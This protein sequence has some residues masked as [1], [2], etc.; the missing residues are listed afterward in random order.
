MLGKLMKYEL[1]ATGRIM[2]P[3]FAA[4]LVLAGLTRLSSDYLSG[5]GGLLKAMA[6]IITLLF[7][8][9]CMVIGLLALVLMIQ[10][11]RDNLLRDEGYLMHTLPVSTAQNIFSKL[12]TSVI[13]YFGTAVVGALSV[14]VL[15]I[16]AKNF[17]GFLKWLHEAIVQVSPEIAAHGFLF[18][19]EGILCVTAGLS[20]SAMVIYASMALGQRFSR[21]RGLMSVLIF[22]GINIA[23]QIAAG[24]LGEGF[25]KILSSAHLPE[26]SASTELHVTLLGTMLVLAVYGAV[27]YFITAGTLKK[28]LNLE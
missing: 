28:H 4:V 26:L 21:R 11:F 2:L 22:F 6:V 14:S 10:R 18:L 3:G 17:T 7:V 9:S 20:A 23:T 25:V 19:L 24:L 16:N 12:L 15:V 5:R 8:L 27:F 1:R 13:W